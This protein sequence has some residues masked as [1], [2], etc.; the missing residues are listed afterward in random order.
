MYRLLFLVSACLG[1]HHPEVLGEEP[2]PE[3]VDNGQCIPIRC[4]MGVPPKQCTSLCALRHYLPIC[5]PPGDFCL[6]KRLVGNSV[7]LV[8]PDEVLDQPEEPQVHYSVLAVFVPLRDFF[9]QE[10]PKEE[11]VIYPTAESYASVNV[12][13]GRLFWDFRYILTGLFLL[14]VGLVVYELMMCRVQSRQDRLETG[15]PIKWILS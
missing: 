9:F 12:H 10:A 7:E 4:E 2:D 15:E 11:E 8:S 3:D 14:M 1:A 13:E 5:H 6:C